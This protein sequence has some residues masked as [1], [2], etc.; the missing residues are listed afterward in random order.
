MKS[1][2]MH[3]YMIAQSRGYKGSFKTFNTENKERLK[4]EVSPSPKR[5]KRATDKYDRYLGSL[6]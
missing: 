1:T 2:P 5:S 3:L 4:L 6:R